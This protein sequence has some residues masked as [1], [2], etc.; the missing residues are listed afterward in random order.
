MVKLSSVQHPEPPTASGTGDKIR[1][2]FFSFTEITDP[3]AHVAYNAWHQLDHLPEQLPVPGI[4]WGQRWV[5]TPACRALRAVD[6]ERLA[7]IHY[8]TLYLM[9]EPVTE[10]LRA[11]AALA[12]ELHRQDRFFEARRSRLSGPFDVLGAAA[13]PRVQVSAAAVPYRPN[14][15]VYVMV[16]EAVSDDGGDADLWR[17]PDDQQ[18]LITVDGVAGVWMFAAREDGLGRWR[19]GRHR[20]TVCYLDGDPLRVAKALWPVLESRRRDDLRTVFAGPFET[21]TPWHWDWFEEQA[22]PAPSA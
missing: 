8:V 4:A 2:G 20:I 6:G 14:T 21:V 12:E 22:A 16:E 15:G 11:F 9:T 1:I 13:A 5:S 18:A 19:P 7:P 3:G 17:R 10:T